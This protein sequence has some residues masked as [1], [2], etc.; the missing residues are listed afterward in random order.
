MF[1]L[2]ESQ[3]EVR[4]NS[5]IAGVF[6]LNL[7]VI[8]GLKDVVKDDATFGGGVTDDTVF[9]GVSK[10]GF[11]VGGKRVEMAGVVLK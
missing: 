11:N 8:H 9:T 6:A 5:R 7:G 10:V 1:G 4:V 2:L 3:T